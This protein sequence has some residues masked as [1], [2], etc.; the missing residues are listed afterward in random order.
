MKNHLLHNGAEGGGSG[1]IGRELKEERS[2]WC[3][4]VEQERGRERGGGREREREGKWKGRK[5][6]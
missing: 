4:E 1:C 3:K 2:V 5:E 6:R